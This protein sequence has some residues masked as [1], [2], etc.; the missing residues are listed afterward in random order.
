MDQSTK[1]AVDSIKKMQSQGKLEM[2]NSGTQTGTSEA[3]LI[4]RIQEMEEW[5]SG[6]E[7]KIEEMD[8]IIK[9]NVNIKVSGH[10][11]SMISETL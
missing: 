6:S 11:T 7:D 1:V 8:S 2:R 9:E 5:I 4:N 3:S 10:K